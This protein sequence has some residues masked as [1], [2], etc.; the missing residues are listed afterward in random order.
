MSNP[1]ITSLECINNQNE[2]VIL[3]YKFKDLDNEKA[4]ESFVLIFSNDSLK[5]PTVGDDV[6]LHNAEM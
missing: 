4:K 3:Q 1:V 5:V 6:K 2:G